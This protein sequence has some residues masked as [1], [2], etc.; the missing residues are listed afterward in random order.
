MNW[1][2]KKFSDVLFPADTR[3]FPL[4]HKIQKG[5]GYQF[6]IQMDK[7]GSF[8]GDKSAGE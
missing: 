1:K 4:R 8:S 5:Y 6:S 7:G 2:T 3:Y